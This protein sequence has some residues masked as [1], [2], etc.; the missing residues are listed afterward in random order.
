M[1]RTTRCCD[2]CTAWWIFHLS[3]SKH[4]QTQAHARTHTLKYVCMYRYVHHAQLNGR[5]SLSQNIRRHVLCVVVVLL[6]VTAKGSLQRTPP[7]DLLY[8]PQRSPYTGQERTLHDQPQCVTHL[9]EWWRPLQ[10][11]ALPLDYVLLPSSFGVGLI[12]QNK[13]ESFDC[14]RWQRN[15]LAPRKN[16][17]K[18]IANI[19]WLVATQVFVRS[20]VHVTTYYHYYLLLLVLQL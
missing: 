3:H 16:I 19:F 12:H 1:M 13:R 8:C 10:C 7:L 15:D 5:F 2:K 14:V 11:F 9:V 6:R 20:F 4:T 17:A 18:G